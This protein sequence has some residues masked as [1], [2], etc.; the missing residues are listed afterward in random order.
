MNNE[1]C[2]KA[3][4]EWTKTQDD[5]FR[6]ARGCGAA[7][8]I[9]RDLKFRQLKNLTVD[10]GW[11][12]SIMLNATGEGYSGE[13]LESIE[14]YADAIYAAL[15]SE[16]EKDARIASLK[17]EIITLRNCDQLESLVNVQAD[18][19]ASLEAK[20]ARAIKAICPVR[21]S[22]GVAR[23]VMEILEAND[24]WCRKS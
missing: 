11:F 6:I 17:A 12:R 24:E 1:A 23:D 2:R 5:N 13:E 16:T 19:I 3:F 4:E 9:M 22:S 21:Y 7:W 14:L 8:A 18:K 10:K 15:P 20:I